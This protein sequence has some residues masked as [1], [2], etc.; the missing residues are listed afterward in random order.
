MLIRE[1][2]SAMAV[3]RCRKKAAQHIAGELMIEVENNEVNWDPRQ[4][5]HLFEQQMTIWR[6]Y[7]GFDVIVGNEGAL[8][9]FVHHDRYAKSVGGLLSEEDAHKV[10]KQAQVVPPDAK[11]IRLREHRVDELIRTFR[12]TYLLATA[13]DSHSQVEVEINST[14]REIIAVRPVPKKEK[15][16]HDRA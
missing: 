16:Q 12:A 8:I 7:S 15:P 3:E 11:L 1:Q 10:V 4:L 13:L 14:T 5:R 6:R 2:L 9:G